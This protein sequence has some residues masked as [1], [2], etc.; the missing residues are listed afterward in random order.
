MIIVVITILLSITSVVLGN[1]TFKRQIRREIEALFSSSMDISKRF[2]YDQL[3]GLPEPVQRYFRFSLEDGQDYISYARLKHGGTFR[4]SEGQ[5]WMPI[6]GEEY[7]T[8]HKLGFVWFAKVSPFPL[9]S[10]TARD[11][12]FEGKGSM[13]IKLLSL[14]TIGDAK[15]NE[16]DQAAL[17]RWFSE[18]AWFPTALLPSEKLHWE[19]IDP[20]SAKGILEDGGLKVSLIFYFNEK[21]EIT[22]IVGNRF[23]AVD[24]TFSED[25]WIGYYREYKRV[26][27]M[28]IPHE[29]EVAW[30]LDSG[31][32]NYA[33]FSVTDIEFNNPTI[34]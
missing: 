23:R 11:Q 30:N 27:N 3:S 9:F 4:Q 25:E 19:E 16:M 26:D 12:Y 14:I 7:F 10:I 34:Y 32:F 17:M 6:R 1:M 15:G 28:M 18:A 31:E 29:V 13:L 33:K 5:G 8:A 24:D 20:N 2:T 21:G 22:R